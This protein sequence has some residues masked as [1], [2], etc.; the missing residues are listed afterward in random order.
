VPLI[1]LAGRLHAEMGRF[2][3]TGIERG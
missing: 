1:G 3:E 2:E